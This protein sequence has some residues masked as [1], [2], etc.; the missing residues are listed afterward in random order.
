MLS[1]L[2]RYFFWCTRFEYLNFPHPY[3]TGFFG[4]RHDAVS[5]G[6]IVGAFDEVQKQALRH[7]SLRSIGSDGGKHVK[8]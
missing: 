4:N 1:G 7:R 2:Q 3:T 6:S 8:R 5:H